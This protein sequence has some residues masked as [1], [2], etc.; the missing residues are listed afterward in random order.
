MHGLANPPSA[1]VVVPV[2]PPMD[3]AG[4]TLGE[5]L[6]ILGRHVLHLVTDGGRLGE[7][8]GEVVVH[9]PGEPLPSAESGVLLITGG[10]AIHP[11]TPDTI[12]KAGAAGY[13]AVVVKAF[14]DDLVGLAQVAD[15]ARVALLTTP[16]EMAWRRLDALIS[17]GRAPTF[18]GDTDRFSSIGL[19]DLFALANAIAS[20]IGGA[21]TIED[22]TGR[23]IAYSNLPHQEIDEIRRLGILGR[24]TPDRPTNYEEYQAVLRSDSPVF[25]ESP[26]P[27]F[28]SRLAVAV[29]AGT[30]ALGVIWVLTDRPPIV[31]RAELVLADAAKATALHLLRSRGHRD[32]E[33]AQRTEA[34]RLLLDGAIAP[35]TAA[36][37]LGVKADSASVVMV[38]APIGDNIEPIL[39]AARIVDLVTLY[40]EAWHSSA[41]CVTDSGVVYAFLPTRTTDEPSP[42]LLKLAEDLVATIRRSGRL[43]VLVG[44]GSCATGLADV[45]ESRAM[46]DRVLAVLNGRSES[47]EPFLRVA[48]AEQVRTEVVLRTVAEQGAAAEGRLLGP[49]RVILAH[50]AAHGTVYAE[51]LLIY[52][53]SFGDVVRASE[54]L[55]IH[56]NTM[57]YR[58]R[59]MQELF[60]L[61]MDDGDEI[62][63]IWLQLRL[64]RLLG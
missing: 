31:A 51:S 18:S 64:L 61:R 49:V 58:V 54:A 8:I 28:S 7:Q 2:E 21:I 14:G 11:Q 53:S 26:S 40:C 55:N 20:S 48:S 39:A 32:P 30:E 36:T 29:R 38:I 33:R 52:L 1:T 59:R 12:R 23:V 50:D 4:R 62:L 46:A 34:L 10:R 17:S 25:F 15:Q 27:E 60:D 63:A 13:R 16:D 45:V 43:E 42:R 41:L 24:Q 35:R 47:G 9:G 57:R 56:E 19:G 3:A 37:Q 6:D 5:V 44:I 22:P